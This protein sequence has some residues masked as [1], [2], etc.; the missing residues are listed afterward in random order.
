[1]FSDKLKNL[2]IKN[3]LTQHQ[4]AAVLGV[5]QN[6]IYNWEKGKRE[7]NF[8]TLKKICETLHADIGELISFDDVNDRIDTVLIQ[9]ELI[10]KVEKIIDV[11]AGELLSAYTLLNETGRFTAFERV[12]ELVEIPKYRKEETSHQTSALNA[13]HE[14]TDIEVTEEMKKYV[15]DIM[16]DDSEWE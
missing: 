13:A 6:A 8:S 1:M 15:D 5:S 2:R 16:K 12:A 4:L 14:R 11:N 10:R 9:D 7:P 3:G